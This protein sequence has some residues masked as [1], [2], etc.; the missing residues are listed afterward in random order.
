MHAD[1]RGDLMENPSQPILNLENLAES[2]TLG[3][4]KISLDFIQELK[5][6]SLDDGHLAPEVASRLKNPPSGSIDLTADQHLS[7]ELFVATHNSAQHVY[8]SVKDAIERRY[9]ES[10]LL[11]LE[12]V[13]QL[14]VEITG[15]FP[16]T[17][18]MCPNSCIAYT[19][20]FKALETC[21]ICGECRFKNWNR[22]KQVFLTIPVGPQL[23]ALKRNIDKAMALRYRKLHTES[24]LSELV[25]NNGFPMT[26][27]NL[28]DSSQYLAAFDEGL[29]KED[30]FVLM[31]SI[32]GTQL[33]MSKQSDCWVCM[34]VVF[35]HPPDARYKKSF[36]FPAFTIPRPN[37]PRNMDSFLYRSL[38]HLAALQ[39]DGL[40]TWDAS[41]VSNVISHPLFALGTADGPDSSEW[42]RWTHG[43]EWLPDVLWCARPSKVTR[44]ALLSSTSQALTTL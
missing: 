36:V 19:G 32:D 30:D 11:S 18:H 43:K 39:K 16:I 13:K 33:F 44:L 29:I 25:N 20:P 21:P 7:L 14:T 41:K 40:P 37:A 5:T 28:F 22:P 4:I 8:I 3:S 15:I 24:L 23:Q 2:A 6:A 42:P 27:G 1:E 31:L 35:D 34:W 17:D 26:Y 9:P 38:Q 12:R 10:K